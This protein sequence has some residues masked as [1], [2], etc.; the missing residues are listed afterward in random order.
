MDR[1]PALIRSRRA[2]AAVALILGG[3][4]AVVGSP[5]PVRIDVSALAREIATE[6]DHVD[7]IV[8]ADWIRAR[9]PGLRV[10]DVRTRAEFDEFHL[11]T[12]ESAPLERI[13][14]LRPSSSETLVLYSAGGAHA[15][16]AWVLLRAIGHRNVFFLAGGLEEWM[17]EVM[18]PVIP[19]DPDL[20]ATMPWSKIVDV[21][22]YF[23]GTPT[24][25][26]EDPQGTGWRRSIDFEAGRTSR[27]QRPARRWR[28]GC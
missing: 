18:T 3:L 2:L 27:E 4:A 22:L 6:A 16:Q 21:S 14:S 9:R 26:P 13:A 24:T 20:A 15:A 10:L 25:A 19:D 8:L 12:A 28:R 7:A 1:T 11:P 23:G 17:A 5:V